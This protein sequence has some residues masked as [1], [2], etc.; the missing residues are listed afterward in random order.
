MF[1]SPICK[2]KDG[3]SLKAYE[4]E[5][6]ANEAILYVKSRYGNEQVCYKCSKCGY[7]H[8]SPKKRQTPNHTSNCLDST[9]KV[10]HAYPTRQSAETRA[11]IIFQE[12]GLKLFVYHCEQ[13][14]EYHL[15]HMQY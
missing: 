13:F 3:T 15:T 5:Y 7:W 14:G 9:G 1:D 2:K 10:K 12:K 6:E 11:K 4:T 8:L